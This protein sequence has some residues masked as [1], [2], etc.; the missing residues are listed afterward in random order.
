[1][2]PTP[3]P[4]LTVLWVALGGAIGSALRFGIAEWFRRVPALAGLP[5]STLAVNVT[6]S[7][8]L[9]V[10]AGW[11]LSGAALAPEHRAFVMIG[12]LGGYTTFSTFALEGLEML[13]AGQVG[14]VVL[15]ATASVLLSV[16]AAAAG[17]ALS[18]G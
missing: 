16:G 13:L 4:P 8:V 12:I 6:G 3:F 1:M 9:G 10:F 11:L 2:Q 7:L 5:W 18:R 15:Y 14:R 17:F